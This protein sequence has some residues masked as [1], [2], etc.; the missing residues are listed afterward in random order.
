MNIAVIDDQCMIHEQFMR[1]LFEEE[2]HC[3]ADEHCFM[4][5]LESTAYD[6]I[7]LDICLND[8]I[9]YVV[10]EAVRRS[11]CNHQSVIVYM[12][13]ST[14]YVLRLFKTQPY[15]FLVKPLEDASLR[16]LIERIRLDRLPHFTVQTR[17]SR[18]HLPWA[19][20]CSFRS[21][22]HRIY[23]STH[24]EVHTMYGKLEDLKLPSPPFLRIHQSVL[25]NVRRIRRYSRS[26]IELDNGESFSISRRYRP[27]VMQF[28]MEVSVG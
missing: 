25:I 19:S 10:G 1:S 7:F 28:M 22:T 24:N 27:S 11:A 23:I 3:F 14:E 18:V 2:V 16:A 26:D 12:S 13:V 6:V 9:G 17:K 8:T 5:T 4:D 15:D 21:D 20:I